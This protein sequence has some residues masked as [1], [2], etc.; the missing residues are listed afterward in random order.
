M[1]DEG[2]MTKRA[3]TGWTDFD[4]LTDE[5]AHAAAVRDADAKPLTDQ[6]MARMKQTP[7]A[8]II[9]RAL[10][11]SQE[12]FAARYQV[13]IGTLRDWEQGRTEPD[14]AAKAYLKVIA[15]QPDTVSR[16]LSSSPLA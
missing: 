5:Q 11:L 14:R 12:E 8:K 6:D 15:S 13:P 4:A 2:T 1:N 9:R 10:G 3:K 16:I 7:R